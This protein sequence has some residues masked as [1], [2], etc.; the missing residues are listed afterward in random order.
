MYWPCNG[1]HT[2]KH[3][4]DS[5][6]RQVEVK[7]N[8]LRG[9]NRHDMRHQRSSN[10]VGFFSPSVTVACARLIDLSMKTAVFSGRLINGSDPLFLSGPAREDHETDGAQQVRH[11]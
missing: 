7:G 8:R 10:G 11:H 6:N 1:R 3:P 5:N 2:I 9:H 4:L